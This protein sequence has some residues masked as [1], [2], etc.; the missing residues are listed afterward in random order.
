MNN[1]ATHSFILLF[2]LTMSAACVTGDNAGDQPDTTDP[3]CQ[4]DSPA[5]RSPGYPF[6]LALYATEVLPAVVQTCS[7]AGCHGAPQGQGGFTVWA[8]A[9]QGNCDYART[10]NAIAAQVDLAAPANSA[11]ISAINGGNPAHP[12]TLG[13]TDP[14][15]VALTTYVSD[16]SDRYLADGGAGDTAPPGASPFDYAVFQSTIQPILD[17][18]GGTGCATAG[19]HGTGAGTFTLVA[20]PA[21]NSPDME[22]NFLA[23]TGRTNLD[24]A[25]ASAFYRQATTRHGGGASTVVSAAEA[26]SILGW[27]EAAVVAAGENGD[28]ANNCPPLDRFNVGVF[29]DQIMP[30]L[31]GELDLNS[32]GPGGGRTGCTAS[33]CHGTQRG[34]GTLELRL[35]R[36]AADNL[37][38]FACFVN[39]Q[40]PS[41]SEVLAC[42]LNQPGCRRYPHPGQAI[43]SG[44]DDLNYQ[45]LLAYLFGSRLDSTPLDFAFFV[46]RINPIF[47][48]PQ[49]VEAG[50]SGRT[51][52]DTTACHGV[53][54][55]GQ[56]PPNGSNFPIIPNAGD[57]ARLTFNYVS[58]ASFVNFLDPDDSSLFL[59]PTN[60][61]ANVADHPSAT[62]LPHPGG[63]D[64]AVDSAEARAIL[65]WAAGLRPDAN[66]FQ[67]NWLV[68]G[69]FPAV[70]ISDLTLVNEV[71]VTP[72]IFDGAGGAFNAGQWDGLFSDAQ[73]VDLGQVFVRAQAVN[74]AA[75]AVAY[76][77]NTTPLPLRV[78]LQID[79]INPARVFVG[80]AL[81]AQDDDGGGVNAIVNLPA[82]GSGGG[83]VRVLVKLLQRTGD[84]ELAFTARLRDELG[85]PLT[86]TSG[87]LV[88]TLGPDGGI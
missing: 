42:P 75:Y 4:L 28:Q 40:T 86:D 2:S 73:K 67:R 36:S 59:Y 35:D 45:R 84:G 46:R 78:Q 70:Q 41:R 38:S 74:R 16:A 66:G 51:C 8:A 12:M 7:A 82:Y 39:L 57:L 13:A 68:A 50:A 9:A 69:D 55:A 62:G 26:A 27:I 21:A 43:F 11:L 25:A 30:I 83:A 19:C 79:T 32:T 34:P 20:R 54:I 88:I 85:T 60:E 48:D 10:F 1:A 17:D 71:A 87:E 80:D 63:T 65:A 37:K 53:N 18:S 61:I 15:L 14:Q 77:V 47:N 56:A 3:E 5:E 29:R 72:R 24:N 52:A 81:V 49:A 23:V 33:L 64:F 31:S 22:A 76:L 6:D 44:A 58:A